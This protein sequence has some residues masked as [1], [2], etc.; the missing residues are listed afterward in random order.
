MDDKIINN[1]GKNIRT[2]L[3]DFDG[4][5]V[6]TERVFFDSFKSILKKK[7]NI[8]I[9]YDDYKKYEMDKNAQLI[10][11][12]KD[13]GKILDD[14]SC[15][16]IMNLVYSEYKNR[17]CLVELDE[18]ENLNFKLIKNLKLIGFNIGLVSTSKIEYINII[19]HKVDMFDLFDVIVSRNDVFKL[20][21]EPDAYLLALK[22]LNISSSEC[23]AIEDSNRGVSSAMSANIKTIKVNSYLDLSFVIYKLGKNY[24]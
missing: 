18:T 4:T 21:P 5:I 9:T 8:V 7:F 12:L 15:D 6:D 13:D 10:N 14:I 1:F 22:N 3:F 2:V 20:K 11:H 24:L 19:L 17:L 23:V 16:Y